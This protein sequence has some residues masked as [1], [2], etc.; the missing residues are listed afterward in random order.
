MAG[1]IPL[2]PAIRKRPPAEMAVP[3]FDYRGA[4]AMRRRFLGWQCRTRQAAVRE[5]QG[6]PDQAMM[7]MLRMAGHD[8]VRVITVLNRREDFSVTPEFRHIARRSMDPAAIRSAAL[9]FLAA[10]YFQGPD[11]FSDSLTAC[12]PPESMTAARLARQERCTLEFDAH[13]HRFQLDC[14]IAELEE[15][16]YLFQATW[17]HNR[18]F[19][20]D[21]RSDSRIFGFC[22]DW[23]LAVDGAGQGASAIE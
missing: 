6:Q 9:T 12:W 18:F 20:R 23:T 4:E 3:A 13:A 1:N 8:P 19:N 16:Q 5:R 10:G 11:R 15:P 17:W 7:P 2:F 22:P 21:L 14:R